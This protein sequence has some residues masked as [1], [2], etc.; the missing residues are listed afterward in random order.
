MAWSGTEKASTLIPFL[1]EKETLT[2]S[3]LET[4]EVMGLKDDLPAIVE[5]AIMD[6][7]LISD[8]SRTH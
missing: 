8:L 3:D 7:G 2:V 1:F 4:L 5:M 6:V